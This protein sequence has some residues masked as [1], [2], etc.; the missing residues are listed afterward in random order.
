MSTKKSLV[1]WDVGGV[2]LELNYTGLYEKGAELTGTTPNEFKQQY[3]RSKLEFG[4][5]N[6]DISDEDYQQQ[7]KQ[8]L[9]NP[10]MSRVDLEN[11]VKKGWGTEIP[12]T[13]E[14]KQR[15]YFQGNAM[16]GIF[17]NINQFAFEYLSKTY[18]KMF[19]TFNPQAPVICSY[20]SGGVKPNLPMYRKANEKAKEL[21]CDNVILV[22][23]K[24]SYLKP[25]M[26]HFNWKGIF[27]TPYLD[28][29]ESIRSVEGHNDD[30]LISN[31]NF[32][33]ANNLHEL[34]QALRGFGIKI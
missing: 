3:D 2:L 33:T 23:D 24:V 34:E 30:T 5:L 12:E 28:H 6:G 21:G 18:L 13:I 27:F 20:D 4:V 11:F 22:E 32:R 9:G 7:L 26:D 1:L 16:V 29:A 19:Q 17:S 25:G 31:P 15:T 14:L 8:M 10:E